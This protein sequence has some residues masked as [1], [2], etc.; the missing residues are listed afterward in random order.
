MG[1]DS[2]CSDSGG[3]QGNGGGGG[4]ARMGQR[5]RGVEGLSQQQHEGTRW[6]QRDSFKG[7][8][9]RRHANDA[10][11]VLIYEIDEIS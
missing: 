8:T 9:T 2:W 3:R 7:T 6:R 11:A 5:W 1:V 4:P 10:S